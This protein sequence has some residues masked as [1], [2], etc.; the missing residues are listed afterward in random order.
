MPPRNPPAKK[1][2]TK[3]APKAVSRTSSSNS[4]APQPASVSRKSSNASLGDKRRRAST[5]GE[6]SSTAAASSSKRVKGT[7]ASRGRQTG[8][9]ARIGGKAPPPRRR[10]PS[11]DSDTLSFVDL[12]N[13]DVEVDSFADMPA[14]SELSSG[15]VTPAR[16]ESDGEDRLTDGG[17]NDVDIDLILQDQEFFEKLLGTWSFILA[18]PQLTLFMQTRSVRSGP[19]ASTSTTNHPMSMRRT[20]DLFRLSSARSKCSRRSTPINH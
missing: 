10:S 1:S 19:A 3:P 15:A 17:G 13:Y 2:A 16:S 11:A 20:M 7:A 12:D 18:L 4:L 6:E 5:I 14:L 8:R 9:L